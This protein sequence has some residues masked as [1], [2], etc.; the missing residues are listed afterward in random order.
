MEECVKRSIEYYGLEEKKA[1]ESIKKMNKK[2]ANYYN[3]YTNRE[4]GS[5]NNYELCIDSS[6]LGKQ[7]TA[8]L[9]LDYI[10]KRMGK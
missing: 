6:V 10:K 1:E 5:I 9:I 2:R 3:F 8:E 7:K 4:W